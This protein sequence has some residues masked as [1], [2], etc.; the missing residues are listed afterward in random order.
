[1]LTKHSSNGFDK[2]ENLTNSNMRNL[3][4]NFYNCML[5]SKRR[6]PF[7]LKSMGSSGKFFLT[8]MTKYFPGTSANF[9]KKNL[10]HRH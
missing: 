4:G 3:N 9:V 10:C 6:L 2:L 5:K 8:R 7:I 1:V